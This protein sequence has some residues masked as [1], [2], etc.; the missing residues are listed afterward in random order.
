MDEVSMSG[1]LI[2]RIGFNTLT[3]WAYFTAWWKL[4]FTLPLG[5][6][7]R[8]KKLSLW[9]AG[10][11][12]AGNVFISWDS[13]AI[14]SG[15]RPRC[16]VLRCWDG[17]AAMRFGGGS[18]KSQCSC[19]SSP[20]LSTLSSSCPSLPETWSLFPPPFT[21]SAVWENTPPPLPEYN[22]RKIRFP[23]RP[24][25]SLTYF[26]V[27]WILPHMQ[28]ASGS[29]MWDITCISL[30]S[31]YKLYMGG[32]LHYNSPLV[33]AFLSSSYYLHLSC[34]IQTTLD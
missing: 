28:R 5:S 25:S 14:G 1:L 15:R 7:V 19:R 24:I 21:L 29:L 30:F 8:G 33:L 12:S 11:S 31:T 10:C 3:Q 22:T 17:P 26:S 4:F 13:S 6:D 18:T 27:R 2:L 9:T 16:W 23:P 34:R 20:Y 32:P